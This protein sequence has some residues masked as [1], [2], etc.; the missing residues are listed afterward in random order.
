MDYLFL[1]E[2]PNKFGLH[3][4]NIINL[5][6]ILNLLL[7]LNLIP[8]NIGQIH[9]TLI[10]NLISILIEHLQIFIEGL[11]LLCE[12]E[13]LFAYEFGEHA[14]A[15]AEDRFLHVGRP[16]HLELGG[17]RLACL[18]HLGLFPTF[19]LLFLW[20]GLAAFLVLVLHD[21]L[22]SVE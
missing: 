6:L 19:F 15:V 11:G 1:L 5:D 9:H 14:Q 7:I 16:L 4:I 10:L 17:G 18:L 13:Q 22:L 21:L 3:N 8:K 20:W 12:G 2:I